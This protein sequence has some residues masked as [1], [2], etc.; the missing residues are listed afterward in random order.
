MVIKKC[1]Y[2]APLTWR[3]FPLLPGEAEADRHPERLRQHQAPSAQGLQKEDVTLSTLCTQ[4]PASLPD[5]RSSGGPLLA[6]PLMA[7]FHKTSCLGLPSLYAALE[8]IKRNPSMKSRRVLL[9]SCHG[10]LFLSQT[11]CTL[12]P[13]HYIVVKTKGDSKISRLTTGRLS[14]ASQRRIA[15]CFYVG[16]TPTSERLGTLM[17]QLK[18]I[19]TK[20]KFLGGKRTQTGSF[21]TALI[22]FLKIISSSIRFSFIKKLRSHK[23]SI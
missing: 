18:W 20:N 7:L 16:T 4:T 19:K 14:S 15:K 11:T 2:H 13:H 3:S 6:R 17:W 23:N 8:I 22:S 9:T 21:F 12:R 10:F 5:N 1:C